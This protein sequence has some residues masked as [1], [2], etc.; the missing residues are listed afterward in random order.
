M[1]NVTVA[2]DAAQRLAAAVVDGTIDEL[3]E[4]RRVRLLALFGSAASATLSATSDLDVA[5]EWLID[6]D[7]VE[8]VDALTAITRFDRVD[9]AVLNGANPTLRARALSG[10]GLYENE[11]GAYAVAQMAAL[12]EWRDTARLRRLDLQRMAGWPRRVESDLVQRRLRLMEE[13]L[14][15]LALLADRTAD[16]LAKGPLDRA[17]AERLVQV[18]VDLAVDINSHLAVAAGAPAPETGRDSFPAAAA[19]A[20]AADLAQRLA[21]SA[22]LRNLLIHRYG[23]IRLDLLVGGIAATLDAYPRY[24]EQ[25]SAHLLSLDGNSR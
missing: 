11:P 22:G 20:L 17:A 18:I 6:G 5:V 10:R 8:L 12:A 21:P 24:I 14:R 4:R 3:C 13:A 2:T 9:V 19:G 1:S 23:D 16:D 25:V 15:D 7:V